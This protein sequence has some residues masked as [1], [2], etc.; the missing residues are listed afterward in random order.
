MTATHDLA[1]ITAGEVRR[2]EFTLTDYELM[3]LSPIALEE[4][5]AELAGIKAI[6]LQLGLTVTEFRDPVRMTQVLAIARSGQ[7]DDRATHEARVTD[8][9]TS[10]EDRQVSVAWL[11]EHFIESPVLPHM[12]L[13]TDF[14][15]IREY[16][17][18]GYTIQHCRPY[19]AMYAPDG[20]LYALV[21]RAAAETVMRFP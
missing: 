21:D 13:V 18:S 8:P 12:R 7:M 14:Q 6:A 11:L 2:V 3:S 1:R 15:S 17:A 20:M 19:C 5:Q 16:M 4:K 10:P 9:A